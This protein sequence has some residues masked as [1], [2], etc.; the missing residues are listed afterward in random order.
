MKS[1]S[2]W[3]KENNPGNYV[4]V[5]VEGLPLTLVASLPGTVNSKPHIT[6]MY[7]PESSVP[8]DHINYVLGRKSL[9]GAVVPVTGVDI[10]DSES[11]DTNGRSEHVG[12]IVLKVNSP[13]INDLHN[14]LVRLGCKHTYN[15]FNAHATLIYNCPIDQ[16][17]IAAKEIQSK[18]ARDGMF[19]TCKGFNNDFIDKNWVDKLNSP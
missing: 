9:L 4:S 14:H 10:F 12:C 6:L 2:S 19:L 18:I 5:D 13:Q 15:P 7:S 3:V 11:D 8:L 16:C 17:R 1:F